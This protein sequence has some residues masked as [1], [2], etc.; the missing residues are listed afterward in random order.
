MMFSYW[1]AIKALRKNKLQTI[2]TM[3]GMTIGVATVV[4]MIAVGSG[5]QQSIERQIRAAGMN[6]LSVAAGNYQ[7]ER[8]IASGQDSEGNDPT[9]DDA[10]K[11]GF[12]PDRL[13]KTLRLG[14][15][16]AGKGSAKTLTL[17]DAAEIRKLPLIQYVSPGLHDHTNVYFGDSTHF[18]AMHGESRDIFSIRRAWTLV[19]GRFF[20]PEEEAAG[21]QVVVLGDVVSQSLFGD[22]NPVGQTITL[23]KLPYTIVGVVASNSWT[24]TESVGDDQFDAVYLPIRTVQR[25]LNVPYLSALTL[26]TFSIG[27]VT[28]ASV[29]VTDLLRQRHKIYEG[30][31]DDFRVYTQAGQTITKTGVQA[32]VARAMVGSGKSLENVTLDELAKTMDQSSRTMTVLL[33]CIGTVSMIVGGIGIMNI[34]LLSVVER[35]REIGI[36]RAVGARSHDVM[37]QFLWESVTLSLSGGI[38]GILIGV[39]VSLLLQA[40]GRWATSISFWSV[41]VSFAISAIIG[42][43]FGYYPARKAAL[44][45]PMDSLRYETA[46]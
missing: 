33:T 8:S 19:F 22:K 25:I 1:I 14:D 35:T 46:S 41:A 6:I 34:M 20:T 16:V 15:F 17:E 26:S 2:L 40:G 21:A 11:D 24:A 45:S 9:A 27:D 5:A 29:E 18:T 43:F 42:V 30:S 23:H 32:E 36:R 3:I 37:L 39:L 4:T 31:P 12:I 13:K 28:D 38:L 7:N 10:L 44:V